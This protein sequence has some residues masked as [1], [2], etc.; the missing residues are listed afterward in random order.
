MLFAGAKVGDV[1]R[2][3]ADFDVDGITIISV[4]PPKEKQRNEPERIEVIGTVTNQPAVTTALVEKGRRRERSGGG[5]DRGDRGDRKDRG[6]GRRGAP[7][8]GDRERPRGT[9]PGPGGEQRRERRPRPERPAR[10]PIE[11]KP[12]PKRLRPGRAHRQAVMADLPEEHKAIAEQVLRGGIPAMRQAIDKQ[13]EDNR[14]A[15]QP[16]INAAPLIAIAEELTPR[17]RLAEWQDRAEAALADVEELD[18]RDLRSV[19]V[20]AD[21]AAKDEATR[22]QADELRA[23]LSR[24]VEAEQTAW[25]Q[26]LDTLL[27]DGRVVRALRVS[28]RPP[29]AGSPFPAELSARL[30]EAASAALTSD[31]SSDR[32]AT[33]IDALAFAPV[34][35]NVKPQG[36][37]EKP[38]DELRAAVETLGLADPSGRRRVRHRSCRRSLASAAW[39]LAWNR[40]S[41]PRQVRSAPAGPSSPAPSRE[42]APGESAQASPPDGES[43]R[44]VRRRGGWV[45]GRGGAHGARRERGASGT[46]R[47]ADRSVGHRELTGSSQNVSTSSG[48]DNT[49]SPSVAIA[50]G[51]HAANPNGTCSSAATTRSWAVS[52]MKATWAGSSPSASSTGGNRLGPAN[53]SLNNATSGVQPS[54]LSSRRPEVGCLFEHNAHRSSR[55]MRSATPGNGWARSVS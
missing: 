25:L 39:W 37:P 24:R 32:F 27:R 31:T 44:R 9:G 21:A 45:A 22:A 12:K 53:A 38:T 40:S 10:P 33:V 52:P 23:A 16:E 42:P 11:A 50:R 48:V 43:A 51:F 36:V 17:L 46:G 49:R 14:A 2:A 47:T 20:A 6:E 4:Q 29:K 55:A 8:D 19:V 54:R 13:N 15:G 28:S 1:V 34:R 41:R 35:Q 18:L 5:R 3:D 30:T 7:R 26:E